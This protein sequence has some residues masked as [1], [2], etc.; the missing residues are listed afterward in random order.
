M[1]AEVKHYARRRTNRSTVTFSDIMMPEMDGFE[2]TTRLRELPNHTTTPVVF[3]TALGDF[4]TRAQSI[5]N[6]GCDL[7]AKPFTPAEL[8]VKGFTFGLKHR[9]GVLSV[10][11]VP[12]SGEM[13]EAMSRNQKP[14]NAAIGQR[15][16]T[17]ALAAG[18][19]PRRGVLQFRRSGAEWLGFNLDQ[20]NSAGT[21]RSY[22]ERTRGHGGQRFRKQREYG[23][24]FAAPARTSLAGARRVGN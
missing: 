23:S 19:L 13:E 8:L 11:P 12:A 24:G 7:V 4:G 14:T 18:G 1:P 3:V 9:F 20:G 15:T 5:M 10:T 2:F 21:R 22:A 17:A 6:G 16:H